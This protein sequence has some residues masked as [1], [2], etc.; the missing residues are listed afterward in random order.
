MKIQFIIKSFLL[1]ISFVLIFCNNGNAVQSNFNITGLNSAEGF[2]Y[3]C[4]DA[5][6]VN[7]DGYDD[8]II[9]APEYSN[10]TGRVYIFFGGLNM[11]TIPDVRMSGRSGLLFRPFRI[12]SRRC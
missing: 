7:N 1:I 11:D 8:L 4:S 2:G 10:N 3:S 9:S 5:G 6:D 12:F